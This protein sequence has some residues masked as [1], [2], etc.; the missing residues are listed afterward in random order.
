[1][2]KAPFV[3]FL[4]YPLS[5]CAWR[6]SVW[7]REWE[8]WWAWPPP[9]MGKVFSSFLRL[10]H[11][12]TRLT[13]HM[14]PKRW[15]IQEKSLCK[16]S[17]KYSQLSHHEKVIW[18][19][20]CSKELLQTF[21]EWLQRLISFKMYVNQLH[22]YFRFCRNTLHDHEGSLQDPH[23]PRKKNFASKA[24]GVIVEKSWNFHRTAFGWL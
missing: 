7:S 17:L 1:M 19:D 8:T 14:L 18:L 6:S 12:H 24:R 16:I 3:Q 22:F 10:R 2:C 15:S 13:R 23:F 21:H 4:T 20:A 5:C 9:Q 11:H